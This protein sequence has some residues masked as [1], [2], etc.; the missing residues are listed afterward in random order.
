MQRKDLIRVTAA[1]WL[2]QPAPRDLI[3]D[4]ALPESV[5]LHLACCQF[6]DLVKNANCWFRI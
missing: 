1:N 2:Y 6:F 5:D 4:F 3:G